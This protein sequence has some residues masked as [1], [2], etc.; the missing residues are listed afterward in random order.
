MS[1]IKFKGSETELP[2]TIIH[3][4][5]SEYFF[6]C[7]LLEEPLQNPFILELLAIVGVRDYSFSHWDEL[8]LQVFIEKR[9]ISQ[10]LGVLSREGHSSVTAPFSFFLGFIQLFWSNSGHFRSTPLDSGLH[11]RS[12][13]VNWS[14]SQLGLSFC[15]LLPL[16]YSIDFKCNP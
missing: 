6:F 1:W 3:P 10:L 7:C 11:F 15:L 14:S 9:L 4:Y 13:K 12:I 5:Q 2:R 8:M 16:L